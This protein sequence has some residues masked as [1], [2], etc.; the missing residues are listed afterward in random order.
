M[1]RRNFLNTVFSAGLGMGFYSVSLPGSLKDNQARRLSYSVNDNKVTFYLRNL[2]NPLKIIQISDTHLWM[3]DK[4]GEA[5]REYSQ[6]MA[7]AYNVTKHF[8]TGADTNPEQSFIEVLDIAVKSKADLIALTGDIFSFP[9]ES[10]IEWAYSELQKTGIP[11]IYTAGNHDWH[12]EGMKGSS[13]ELRNTWTSKRLSKMYQG[14]DPLMAAFDLKGIKVL[15]IDNSIYNLLPQQLDFL[16]KQS[17]DGTP[18]IVMMHIPMYV[19]GKGSGIGDPAWGAAKDNGYEI[20]R[21]ERWPEEGHLKSTFDFWDELFSSENLM[22]IFTGHNHRQYHDVIEGI[23]QFVTNA[24][25]MGAYMEINF[26]DI[27]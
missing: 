12:Y 21:R 20:E 2:S 18:F 6:R 15:A 9:S 17:K 16:R 23:P 27:K 11:F 7:K 4:R 24:N 13:Q 25:S 3:D 10:A 5:Y 1:E 26:Q 8:R 14:D 19:P 22:G